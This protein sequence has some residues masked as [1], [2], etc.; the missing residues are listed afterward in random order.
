MSSLC[1]DS[2]AAATSAADAVQMQLRTAAVHCINCKCKCICMCSCTAH[3]TPAH[4]THNECDT[5]S[6][7]SA[8]DSDTLLTARVSATTLQPVNTGVNLISFHPPTSSCIL[9]CPLAFTCDGYKYLIHIYCSVPYMCRHA[10][11]SR[12][13]DASNQYSHDTSLCRP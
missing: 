13:I 12:Q 5:N 11:Y 9:H 10:R 8:V 7:H 3:T 6:K 4:C 1:F 2:V